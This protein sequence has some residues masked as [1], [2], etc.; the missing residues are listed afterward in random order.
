[1]KKFSLDELIMLSEIKYVS[2]RVIPCL[3]VHDGRTVKGINF[4]DLIMLVIQ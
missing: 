4:L 3:D 1:M 2:N